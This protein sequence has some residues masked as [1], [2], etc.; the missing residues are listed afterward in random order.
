MTGSVI[1]TNHGFSKQKQKQKQKNKM[2]SLVK[3]AGKKLNH[4]TFDSVLSRSKYKAIDK[5]K[6]TQ[7]RS[8]HCTENEISRGI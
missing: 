7:Q 6:R 8:T 5:S 3:M 2:Q 1:Y 4:L